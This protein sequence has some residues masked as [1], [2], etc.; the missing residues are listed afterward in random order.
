MN[1]IS[2]II[3]LLASF[4]A[5][6]A[7]LSFLSFTQKTVVGYPHLILGYVIPS[8]VG[9]LTGAG[10]FLLY[11]RSSLLS[12]QNTAELARFSALELTYSILS[13][14]ILLCLFSHHSESPGRVSDE[15]PGVYCPGHLRQLK[16]RIDRHVSDPQSPP[17][18]LPEEFRSNTTSGQKPHR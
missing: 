12:D 6:A 2:D 15:T 13:G 4:I 1:S 14:S 18:D 16:R 5:G 10:L 7:I 8:M 3:K 17:V 11:R 9:G